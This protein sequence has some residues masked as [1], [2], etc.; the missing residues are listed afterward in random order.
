MNET[1]KHLFTAA[2]V[3]LCCAATIGGLAWRNKTDVGAANLVVAAEANY[4]GLLAST[5]RYV[6]DESYYTNLVK[7]LKERYV[8]SVADETKLA[9]GSVK[10]MVLSLSDVKSQYMDADEFK[11]YNA[12]MNGR[13]EGIGALLVLD[14]R[15]A[16]G[17]QVRPKARE[18]QTTPDP[19]ADP[20]KIPVVRVAA[21]TPG[22][23]AERAGVR[24]GDWVES[25]DGRYVLSPKL[26]QEFE[27]ARDIALRPDVSSDK[28]F[29]IRE[30]LQAKAESM[31]MPMRAIRKLAVGQEGT[32]RV[33]F[34]R[35]GTGIP[36]EINKGVSMLPAWTIIADG[37][38]VLRFQPGVSERLRDFLVGKAKVRLDLRQSGLGSMAEMKK[39]LALLAPR[40][41]YGAFINKRT[42]KSAPMVIAAGNERPPMIEL[43]VDVTTRGPAEVFALAL[44]SKPGAALVTG[45][46]TAGESDRIEAF[47]LPEGHG[48]TLA[49]G[50]YQPAIKVAK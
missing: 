8:E 15:N 22:G 39:C 41:T 42:K 11:A 43:L 4:E 26:W 34:N 3:V 23:P 1:K 16:Q 32:V 44:S 48:Y 50:V 12:E 18:G 29:Q 45:G 25:V 36:V 21:V 20:N 2:S 27:R 17:K 19:G 47:P 38:A 24:P 37:T 49:M 5:G 40:G 46:K 35:N 6:P 13:Y 30:K 14:V 28:K 33:L 9:L 10:E 7:L 31:I